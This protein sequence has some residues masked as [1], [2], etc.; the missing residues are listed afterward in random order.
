MPG[1]DENFYR[2]QKL[3]PYVFAVINEMKAKAR[4]DQL[5]VVDLGMGNP[6][7][8]TPSIIVDKLVEAARNPR[9][10][11]YS[12]SR[13]IARL[14]EEIAKRYK[15]NYD[16]DLDPDTEAIVTMGA[17]DALA[18]LLFA[19]IG[20]GDVVVSPNPAYPIHQYGVIMSEGHACMLPMPDPE[21]FLGRLEELY[22][23]SPKPPKMLLISFPHNPTTTCVDL[24]YLTRIVNLARA[25]GTLIVHDFAYA[26]LGFDGYTPPSILQVPGAKEI[27]V[28]IFSMSKSY[29][30][31]GWR[32]GYCLGNRRMIAA[33]ARIKSYLDYGVFQPIQIASIVALRECDEDTVKIREVYKKRS[34]VLVEGLCRAGW[35][36]QPPRGTMFLWAALPERYRA[37]GS[38]EFAKLLM[39]KA[40]VAVSPG[41]GF[42][43][44]GE[45]FVR[46]ALIE[47]EHR[48][49]QATRS[50]GQ[51][52]RRVEE[53]IAPDKVKEP[54]V[55]V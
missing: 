39:Q 19:T 46:F 31:A 26:D 20:P 18:H 16:V 38:L 43:P 35:P 36:V 45:G 22:R 52:L 6:D 1:T 7:G 14:R 48:T 13:G 23:E 50:I 12:V 3:P 8:S 34:D 30:M 17:K 15:R 2:I 11:R 42:G 49:R 24:E 55:Q 25:H 44:M 53:P 33:L 32:V 37:A 4:A 40:L 29:N 9:N 51:F 28:E 54:L 5:D 10:H 41:V 27:A 21:T 47:N